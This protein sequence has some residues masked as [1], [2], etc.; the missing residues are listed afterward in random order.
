LVIP[1][2]CSDSWNRLVRLIGSTSGR[3]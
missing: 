1:R 3:N 2:L